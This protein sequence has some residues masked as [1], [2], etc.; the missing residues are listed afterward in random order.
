MGCFL[1]LKP[2]SRTDDLPLWPGCFVPPATGLN[3]SRDRA[4]ALTRGQ[5][6]NGSFLVADTNKNLIA[7]VQE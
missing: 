7:R 5:L 4:V 6:G 1:S 2:A 3:G